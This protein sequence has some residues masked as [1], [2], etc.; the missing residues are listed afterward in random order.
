MGKIIN[1]REISQL[2]RKLPTQEK[3]RRKILVKKK[4]KNNNDT[5]NQLLTNIPQHLPKVKNNNDTKNQL[6]TNIPQH[7]PLFKILKHIKLC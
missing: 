2:R 3:H 4:V 5:K 7:L 6:L 1:S